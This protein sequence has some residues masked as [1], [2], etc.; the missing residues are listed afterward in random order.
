MDPQQAER[1]AAQR[2]AA[3]VARAQGRRWY[4][5]S[6][7]M[8]V[9][10]VV[11]LVRGGQLYHIL[12]AVLLLLAVLAVSLGKSVRMQAD[13]MEQKL[14]LMEQGARDSGQGTAG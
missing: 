8:C 3:R 1:L 9:V 4:L 11:A 12:A 2:K 10:A 14:D 13:A 7:L 5:R 6:A